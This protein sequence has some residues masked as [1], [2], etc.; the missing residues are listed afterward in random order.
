MELDIFRFLFTFSFNIFN[1]E[2]ELINLIKLPFSIF[3][4]TQKVVIWLAKRK[5]HLDNKSL[6]LN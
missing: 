1:G 3:H 4:W 6:L 5:A 2:I